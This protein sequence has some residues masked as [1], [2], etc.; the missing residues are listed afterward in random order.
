MDLKHLKNL[1]AVESANA[2]CPFAKP[3]TN[4]P[5]NASLTSDDPALIC[6]L[7]IAMLFPATKS[8]HWSSLGPEEV[9]VRS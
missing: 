3:Y 5:A 7:E 2:R 8:R 9:K 4:N 1:D 6:E